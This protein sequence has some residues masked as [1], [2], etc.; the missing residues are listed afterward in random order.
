MRVSDLP[1]RSAWHG[2]SLTSIRVLHSTPTSGSRT[3]TTVTMVPAPTSPFL[4][5]ATYTAPTNPVCVTHFMSVRSKLKAP[6]RITLRGFISDLSE[7]LISQQ[8]AHKRTFNVVDDAGMWIRCCALGLSAT[9][10]ALRNGN[11][12]VLYY[13]TG[14]GSLGSSPGMVLFMKDSLVVQIGIR[15]ATMVKRGEVPIEGQ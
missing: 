15:P 5:S 1:A 13:G 12:V 7:M 11:E 4:V 6:F 2:L 9:S 3:G 10:R 14:R 8:E